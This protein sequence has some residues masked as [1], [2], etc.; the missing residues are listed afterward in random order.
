MVTRIKLNNINVDSSKLYIIKP[1]FKVNV[2]GKFRFY[3]GIIIGLGFS[4]ILNSLFRLVLRFANLGMN[5]DESMSLDYDI[6]NYY[7]LLIGFLSV[8]FAFCYTTY[9]WMSN[10]QIGSRYKT[11]KFRMAQINPIWILFSSMLFFFRLL[12]F[13]M[14]PDLTLEN[15]IGYLAFIFPLFVFLFCWSSISDIFKSGKEILI[16]LTVVIIF[17]SILSTV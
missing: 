3:S 13:F 17:G 4:I 11:Q 6:S 14:G 15:D 2:I 10:P 12:F 7:F 16:S 8:A 1:N 5:F 9:L